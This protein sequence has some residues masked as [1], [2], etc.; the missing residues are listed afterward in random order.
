MLYV[1]PDISVYASMRVCVVCAYGYN[2]A[3][4][5]NSYLDALVHV[6]YT[7]MEQRKGGVSRAYKEHFQCSFSQ[8]FLHC[9]KFFL[10]LHE[11]K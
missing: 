3:V 7:S 4:E 11:K 8:S 1:L 9:H 10:H 2:V 6:G 5:A